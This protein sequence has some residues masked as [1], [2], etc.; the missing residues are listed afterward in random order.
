MEKVLSKIISIA[1]LG[2]FLILNSNAQDKDS[3]FRSK[4]IKSLDTIAYDFF[5]IGQYDSSEHYYKKI[6]HYQ[7]AYY[8]V[9]DENTA[10]TNANLGAIYRNKNNYKRALHHLSIAE[11]YFVSNNPSSPYMGYVYNT[12][13]N[14]YFDYSDYKE[15]ELY[16]RYCL[17]FFENHQSTENYQYAQV[18]VNIGNIL[19]EQNRNDEAIEFLR[20]FE[21]KDDNIGH[22][23]KDM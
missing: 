20:N 3:I 5:N 22:V 13:A 17:E 4:T 11:K 8:G 16:Y 23:Q 9:N 15:A 12:K 2:S 1:L 6:L 10:I 14:I 21:L 18:Y 7:E 19:V